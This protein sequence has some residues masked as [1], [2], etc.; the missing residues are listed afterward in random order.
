LNEDDV[1]Y[2]DVFLSTDGGTTFLLL[3]SNLT[4]PFYE[5]NSAGFLDADYIARV[6]AYSVDF[7]VTKEI[8]SGVY[9][10]NTE[11]S[12]YTY[13]P[14]D[15]SNALSAPFRAGDV[16]LSPVYGDI[17]LNSPS[18]LAIE[19]G[20]TGNMLSWFVDFESPPTPTYLEYS[21]FVDGELTVD[22]TLTADWPKQVSFSLDD[23][24][25]GVHE[26]LLRV[27]NP[28]PYL[29]YVEDS[30]RVT[31]RQ[32]ASNV[33]SSYIFLGVDLAASI[34]ILSSIVAIVKERRKS[35]SE[36]REEMKRD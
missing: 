30:V 32:V 1:N 34:V 23:L 17:I 16:G 36:N 8:A 22:S 25:L 12:R 31:V 3:T 14:G 13:W 9:W 24:E 26:I 10:P 18:D 7:T 35:R 19:A 2:F 5:W 28:A 21:I 27:Y 29:G 33:L 11:V 20:S 15:Y 4:Q 6:R